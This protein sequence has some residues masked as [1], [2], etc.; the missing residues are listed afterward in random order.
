MD[1]L[2][3]LFEDRV[4]KGLRLLKERPRTLT[5]MK[6]TQENPEGIGSFKTVKKAVGILVELGLATTEIVPKNTT[7]V[8]ITEKG[9]ELLGVIEKAL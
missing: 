6:H 8:T 4:L 7:M 9:R 5:G 3:L 2:N 1:P